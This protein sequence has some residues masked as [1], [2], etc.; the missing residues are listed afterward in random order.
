MKC[1]WE[2]FI[3]L[4]PVRMRNR[5]DMLGKERLQEFRLRLQQAP[6]LITSR[7]S[8]WLDDTVRQE[9]LNHIVNIASRY[10]P[11]TSVTISQGFITAPGGHRIGL[12]GEAITVE[13]HMAGIGKLTS[14]CMRV[15]R[16]FPGIARGL[17]NMSGSAIIIGSPGAGKTTLL[18]DMIRQRSQSSG[19]TIAVVDERGEIFPCVQ[20]ELC[21]SSGLHADILSGCAKAQGVSFVMR[22]MGPQTIAVDEITDKKDC[23]ALLQAGWCGVDLLA[24]AHAASIKDLMSRPVYRPIIDSGLFQHVIILQQDKSWKVERMEGYA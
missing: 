3:N 15:A 19:K 23:D 13:G 18:R 1:A 6:E 11:W 17:E 12:C 2:A 8:I 21:F 9:D 10:S 5:V 24:T 20:G 16:D 14:A 22:T 4:L 7:G